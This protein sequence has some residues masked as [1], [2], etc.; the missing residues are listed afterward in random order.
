MKTAT[1]RK[2]VPRLL[3]FIIPLFL[4]A[5]GGK[6]ALIY[7]ATKNE[8]AWIQMRDNDTKEWGDRIKA[9]RQKFES[10]IDLFVVRTLKESEAKGVLTAKGTAYMMKKESELRAVFNANEALSLANLDK[11]IK[12]FNNKAKF[13][14]EAIRKAAEQDIALAEEVSRISSELQEEIQKLA[15]ASVVRREALLQTPDAA[16][17]PTEPDTTSVDVPTDIQN[18]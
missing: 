4:F 9:R 7:V 6:T 11:R 13:N 16:L 17:P 5:C 3:I 8:D 12:A 14:R 1:W 18:P 2:L 10:D 15:Y